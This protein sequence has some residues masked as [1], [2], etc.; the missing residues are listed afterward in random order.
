MGEQLETICHAFLQEE[1]NG[2]LSSENVSLYREFIARGYPITLFT[3]KR[4]QRRQLP[5]TRSSLVAGDIPIV[6]SALKQLKIPLP[7]VNDY[8][9]SLH[10]FLHRRIWK[11]SLGDLVWKLQQEIEVKSIFAKPASRRKQFTGRVFDLF[12]DLWSVSGISH[13]EELFCSEAVCWISEYRVYVINSK[14]VGIHP[15]NGDPS[16]KLE[17]SVVLDAIR[18]LDAAGESVAGYSLDLGVL[19]TGETALVEMNDGFSLGNYGLADEDYTN[20]I[21]ARWKEL[22]AIAS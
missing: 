17:E 6:L 16:V 14:I 22:L 12:H 3:P 4:M 11:S 2:K 5:L 13:K 19:E 9:A 8:P 21:L 20:L 10:K 15:Y 7:P 1:G 18:C